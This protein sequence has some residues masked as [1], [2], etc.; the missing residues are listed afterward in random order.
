M[1]WYGMVEVY[2]GA[3]YRVQ[4]MSVVFLL[5]FHGVGR[6]QEYDVTRPEGSFF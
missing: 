1:V 6:W 4:R 3:L 2:D 5:I